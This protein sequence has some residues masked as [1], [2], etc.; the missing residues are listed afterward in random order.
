MESSSIERHL[1]S[2]EKYIFMAYYFF[3]V[4]F[5]LSVLIRTSF[6]TRLSIFGNILSLNF[7]QIQY[8]GNIFDSGQT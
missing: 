4:I 6:P 1:L 8:F 7:T 3:S 2:S 5:L